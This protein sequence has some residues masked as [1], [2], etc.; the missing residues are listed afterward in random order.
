MAQTGRFMSA[1]ESAGTLRNEDVAVYWLSRAGKDAH[2]LAGQEPRGVVVE[3]QG[4]AANHVDDERAAG[5]PRKL[6]LDHAPPFPK[7]PALAT[8]ASPQMRA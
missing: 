6:A 3:F 5:D 2:L 7:S 1:A 4:D 8:L